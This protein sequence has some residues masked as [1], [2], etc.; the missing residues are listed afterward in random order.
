MW[1]PSEPARD[2]SSNAR[3]YSLGRQGLTRTSGCERYPFQSTVPTA[4]TLQ[5]PQT[6]TQ[7]N[8]E[9][10]ATRLGDEDSTQRPALLHW[11]QHK[12]HDVG[13][14]AALFGSTFIP[15]SGVHPFI[16]WLS[17]HG[18]CWEVACHR[19]VSPEGL[20]RLHLDSAHGGWGSGWFTGTDSRP[21]RVLMPFPQSA[22][23]KLQC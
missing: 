19:S 7:S 5:L 1:W 15:R 3:Y 21:S 16:S 13:K 4:I 6:T 23:G 17:I 9:L 20:L 14:A 18:A 11:P 8:T 12:D 2:E 22:R 10:P